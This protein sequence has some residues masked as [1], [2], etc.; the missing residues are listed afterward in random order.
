[1][2]SI[3]EEVVISKTFIVNSSHYF[4]Q[5][6]YWSREGLR[7]VRGVTISYEGRT[8]DAHMNE[9]DG[10]IKFDSDAIFE[11]FKQENRITNGSIGMAITVTISWP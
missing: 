6:K 11:R 10:R 3:D 5:K 2:P 9:P 8:Y 7:N 4:S 1:M